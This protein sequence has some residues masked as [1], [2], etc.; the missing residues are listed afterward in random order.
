METL[1]FPR[2]SPDD[3][4]SYL[5]S[6]VLT[7]A[8]A[9]NLVKGDVFG[10]PKVR[11]AVRGRPRPALAGREWQGEPFSGPRRAQAASC[12]SW[13]KLEVL[14]MIYMRIL[15]KV[16]GIR[17]E[18]FYMKSAMEKHQQLETANREAAVKL[19]KLNAYDLDRLDRWA[20]ANCVRFCKATCQVLHLSHNNPM[21]R[22]RLGEEC[23]ESCLAEK[24]LGVLVNS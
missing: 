12:S 24:D 5:R 22:Y 3:I 10:N 9:R 15:Q 19:E 2:Y 23:L 6:H 16:Y 18:H 17:L 20:K 1:T 4:I 11:E 7:G 14:H 21:Q 8:E 13:R